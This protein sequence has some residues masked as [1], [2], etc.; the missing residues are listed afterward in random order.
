MIV[1]GG[2]NNSFDPLNTGGRY[3]GQPGPPF[4]LDAHVRR[5]KGKRF[6]A[7]IW[8]PADGGGVNVL[9]N[10]AVVD[11]TDDDGAAQDKLG[12]HTGTFFYQVCETDSGNCSNQVRIVVRETGN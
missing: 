5:Q 9:R 11:T 4:I 10:G 8:S 6:V 1:W 2:L 12:T 7:L 3:C